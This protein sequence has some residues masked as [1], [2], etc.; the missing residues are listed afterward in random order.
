M[1]HFS[2]LN[3]FLFCIYHVARL[4]AAGAHDFSLIFNNKPSKNWVV[5]VAG[6]DSWINY[7]HQDVNPDVFAKV[8]KGDEKLEKKGKKVLKSGPDDNIFIYYTGHG[9]VHSISF[10]VGSLN[11]AEFNDVLASMYSNRMYNELVVYM[12]ACYS[13]S[14]FRDLLP[15]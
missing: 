14:M 13:G 12:D 6:S 2:L 4:E 1:H 11:A 5:L 7:R 3:A 9:A 10:P 15:P 8:L